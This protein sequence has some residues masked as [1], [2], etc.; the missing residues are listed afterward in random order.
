MWLLIGVFGLPLAEIALFIV[1]GGAIGVW[2]TLLW[3]VASGLAGVALMRRAGAGTIRSV[4]AAMDGLQDP[5]RPLAEGSVRIA[6]G[7]LIAMP[8]FLT[9]A[10]GLLLLL[11]GVRAVL[12]RRM[13]ARR[14]MGRPAGGDPRRVVVIETEYRDVT[15]PRDDGWR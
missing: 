3:V 8:G 6:A 14:G 9:D 10:L 7:L 2:P 1:I 12:L 4:S 13:A 15:P 11:P 5:A